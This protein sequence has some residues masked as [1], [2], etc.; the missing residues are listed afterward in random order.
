MR[1]RFTP[2]AGYLVT[3]GE[4]V[5]SNRIF[6]VACGMS[7]EA[8]A[9][10]FGI[11]LWQVIIGRPEAWGFGRYEKDGVPIEGMTYFRLPSLDRR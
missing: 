6:D 10:F 11:L 8:S 5:L 1:R 9:K 2:Q 3:T 7:F 4:T